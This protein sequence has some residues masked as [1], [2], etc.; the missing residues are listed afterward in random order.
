MRSTM[1]VI[2]CA[3]FVLLPHHGTSLMTRRQVYIVSLLEKTE[4]VTSSLFSFQQNI[5]GF[6]SVFINARDVLSLQTVS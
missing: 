5:H 1:V 4:V 6:H 3:I 2:T